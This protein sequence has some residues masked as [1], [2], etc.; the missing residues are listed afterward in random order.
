M[1]MIGHQCPAITRCLGFWQNS[2]QPI[3]EIV[4]VMI[5]SEYL[6]AL[7]TADDDMDAKHRLRPGELIYAWPFNGRLA[8]GVVIFI[9]LWTSLIFLDIPQQMSPEFPLNLH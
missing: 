9:Y 8:V 1:G 4:F 7:N 5:V 3:D 6:T 2:S